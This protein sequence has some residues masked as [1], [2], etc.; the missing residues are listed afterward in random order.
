M[1]YELTQNY[2]NPFN[3]FTT[4]QFSI[5]ESGEVKLLVYN[6]LG[7]QVA[8]L[9]NESKE[10]GVHTINFNATELNS[11]LYIYKLTAGSFSAFKKMML[12]K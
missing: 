4:I 12:L 3:P 1:E 6:I 7:E 5:P 11:G 9:V 10:A 8:E 2:P